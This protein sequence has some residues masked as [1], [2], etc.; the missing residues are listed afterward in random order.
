LQ[1]WSKT[2]STPNEISAN[3][4]ET[5]TST[6]KL[7][8]IPCLQ[9]TQ[10]NSSTT[11]SPQHHSSQISSWQSPARINNSNLNSPKSQ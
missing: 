6:K 2:T 7:I 11:H 4:L 10:S 8:V 5:N 9:P 1:L 3:S